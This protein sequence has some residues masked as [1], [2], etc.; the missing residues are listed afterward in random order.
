MRDDFCNEDLELKKISVD[1]LIGKCTRKFFFH[2]EDNFS[3]M[4]QRL[5]HNFL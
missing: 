4:G 2:L 1:F 5:G 3:V